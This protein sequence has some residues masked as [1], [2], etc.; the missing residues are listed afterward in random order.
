[1]QI[2]SV[3]ES[4][5]V[6]ANAAMVETKE[7]SIAQVIDQQRIVDLPL[8]GRNLTQLLTLTGAG[9]T[10]PAGDLT[11]SKNMLGANAS[12]TFSVAGGQANGVN[13]P[14]HGGDNHDAFSKRY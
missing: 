4:I 2:G 12:G 5:Q 3:T 6:T 1:M 7:N 8:N 11:G 13:I 14:L 9:T 10:A